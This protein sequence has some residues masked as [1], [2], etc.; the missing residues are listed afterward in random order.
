MKSKHLSV[1]EDFIVATSRFS[2]L[3]YPAHLVTLLMTKVTEVPQVAGGK[4]GT[5]VAQ[6]SSS[7][8]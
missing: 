7:L 4:Q 6:I 1:C 5:E 2:E 8:C 3:T